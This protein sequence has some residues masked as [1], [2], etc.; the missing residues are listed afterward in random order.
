MT[1]PDETEG[2]GFQQTEKGQIKRNLSI[3]ARK[4]ERVTFAYTIEYPENKYISI[5]KQF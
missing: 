1:I 3:G 5:Q 2:R 4:S